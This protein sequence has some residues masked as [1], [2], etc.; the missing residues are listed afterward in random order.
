MDVVEY[1]KNSGD[2]DSCSISSLRLL[3]RADLRRASLVR[4]LVRRTRCK[5]QQRNSKC[6]HIPFKKEALKDAIS[7]IPFP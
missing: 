1:V 5:D 3:V 4:V 6:H 2:K 7:Q